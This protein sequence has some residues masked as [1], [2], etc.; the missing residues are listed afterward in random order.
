MIKKVE[1]NLSLQLYEPDEA[2]QSQRKRTFS[3]EEISAG[4]K[5]E[6]CNADTRA[7][8]GLEEEIS[9]TYSVKKLEFLKNELPTYKKLIDRVTEIID[10]ATITLIFDDFYFIP[11]SVQPEFLDYFHR[12]TKGTNLVMKVATIKHRSRLYKQTE[13]SYVGV[14]LEHDIFEIDMDYTLDRFSDLQVFMRQLLEDACTTSG[15]KIDVSQLFSGEGFNQ[16]SMAS[17]GVPRDFLALFV[18]LTNK[19]IMSEIQ[20]I[21]KV[22]VTEAAIN[23]L[24]KKMASLKTDSA[25][26]REIL[27]QYLSIIK[28]YIFSKKRT[29]TF[30]VAKA[31]LDNFP[32]ERQAIRELVDLRL[33]HLIDSNT[34]CAPSDGRRYE[35]YMLD[36]GLYDNARPRNF[37]QIEPG[38]TDEKSRKDEL[39]ASP[40]LE[41][42]SLRDSFLKLSNPDIELTEVNERDIIA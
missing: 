23:N 20:S 26:E 39:R 14:E 22:N 36:V 35:A 30:L 2:V 34:S 12:L 17:G 37:R 9:R 27:E 13:E 40:K 31:D 42:S 19:I 16:L 15:T 32:H 10:G 5:T 21:G 41:L 29:N 11:K 18:S 24:P 3:E 1:K 25:E 7:K 4:G 33:L 8:Q 28:E 6:I 38:S